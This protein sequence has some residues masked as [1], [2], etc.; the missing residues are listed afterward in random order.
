[1]VFIQKAVGPALDPANGNSDANNRKKELTDIPILGDIEFDMEMQI[2]SSYIGVVKVGKSVDSQNPNDFIQ[3][4]PGTRLTFTLPV[5]RILEKYEVQPKGSK[6]DPYVEVEITRSGL[7]FRFPKDPVLN[8]HDILVACAPKIRNWAWQR[9]LSKIPS[10]KVETFKFNI[11]QK[12]FN[13]HLKT[14]EPISFG[15]NDMFTISDAEVKVTKNPGNLVDFEVK[16]TL[17]FARG[18]FTVGVSK[19]DTLWKIEGILSYFYC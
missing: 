18:T 2:A 9:A 7:E 5:R 14:V 8:M 17:Q 11:W 16:S 19:K 1:M 6:L 15:A 12:Q 13:V 4:V 3:L 10:I